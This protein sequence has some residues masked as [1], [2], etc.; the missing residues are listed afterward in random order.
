MIT[1][2]TCVFVAMLCVLNMWGNEKKGSAIVGKPEEILKILH[3]WRD[4]THEQRVSIDESIEGMPYSGEYIDAV[5]H[6]WNNDKVTPE[7]AEF[8]KAHDYHEGNNWAKFLVDF[9]KEQCM[10][11]GIFLRD[12]VKLESL[13]GVFNP[14]QLMIAGAQFSKI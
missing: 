8:L 5:T 9:S 1:E 3:A 4:I 14:D 11:R 2:P 7:L 6:R 12:K 13:K 10:L